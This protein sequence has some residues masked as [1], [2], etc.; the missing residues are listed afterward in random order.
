MIFRSLL[1]I[2]IIG[3]LLLGLPRF[4]NLSSTT[5]PS[6]SPSPS[7]FSYSKRQEPSSYWMGSFHLKLLKPLSWLDSGELLGDELFPVE[8]SKKQVIWKV[9]KPI[10]YLRFAKKIPIFE[11]FLNIHSRKGRILWKKPKALEVNFQQKVTLVGS[12][13]RQ[14]FTKSLYLWKDTERFEV[15]IPEDFHFHSPKPF[16]K[17]HGK[18]IFLDLHQK[19]IEWKGPF[20][21]QGEGALLGRE[22][23]LDAFQ[24]QVRKGVFVEE[25]EKTYFLKAKDF[26]L[27]YH[28]R[29]DTFPLQ[30]SGE[31]L[32]MEWDKKEGVFSF[33]KVHHLYLR[34][35]LKFQNQDL[36]VWAHEGYW[37]GHEWRILGKKRVRIVFKGN[38]ITCSRISFDYEKKRAYLL[39]NLEG[40]LFWD[41]ENYRLPKH[42]NFWGDRGWV[43]MDS[44]FRVQK[45]S[46][47]GNE[48]VLLKSQNRKYTLEGKRLDFSSQSWTLTEIPQKKIRLYGSGFEIQG[49]NLQIQKEAI[50]VEGPLH[51]Y[52]KSLQVFQ[53]WKT[54]KDSRGLF[55]EIQ[56]RLPLSF[57]AQSLKVGLSFQKKILFFEIIGPAKIQGKGLVWEGRNGLLEPENKVISFFHT[58]R[59]HTVPLTIMAKEGHYFIKE[60]KGIFLGEIEGTWRTAKLGTIHF[61][62]E[63]GKVYLDSKGKICRLNGWGPTGISFHGEKIRGQFKKISWNPQTGFQGKGP[64]RIVYFPSKKENLKIRKVEILAK[65]KGIIS[66]NY[67]HFWGKVKVFLSPQKKKIKLPHFLKII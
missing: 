13:K 4:W 16:G 50:F 53:D 8:E 7:T 42:W 39:Q 26:T 5:V 59:I 52:L 20:F 36:T 11:N 27:N 49:K 3:A 21:F 63:T 54:S 58:G 29:P 44:L 6:S 22:D 9:K 60:K 45:A 57:S 34:G 64:L 66:S 40:Q 14:A 38:E 17:L 56:K 47:E 10:L 35:K 41:N 48:K 51:G 24:I 23:R 61:K 37:N 19:K 32:E 67:F 1:G 62:G 18:N 43:Q 2:L 28:P 30:L 46:M 25:R 33:E 31:Y 65:E 12:K 55:H 15:A